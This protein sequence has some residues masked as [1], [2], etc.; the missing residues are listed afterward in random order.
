MDDLVQF[1]GAMILVFLMIVALIGPIFNSGE[2]RGQSF[3]K[4]W[5]Y[6]RKLTSGN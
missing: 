3:Q 1:L 6:F 2:L 5:E 4:K